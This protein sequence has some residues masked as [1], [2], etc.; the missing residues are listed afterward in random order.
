M[1]DIWEKVKD[2]IKE[3]IPLRSYLL[4]IKPIKFVQKKGRSII[5]GCPNRFSCK[6]IEQNYLHLLKETF[7][8]LLDE[9]IQI[10]LR[11]IPKKEE[12]KE[13]QQLYL[14]DSFRYEK[15]RL[16]KNF[17]FEKFVVG[18]CNEFAY[19][20]SSAFAKNENWNYGILLM[21]AEPGLGKTHLSQAAGNLILSKNPALKVV[22][23]TVEDFL[24]DLIYAV[25]TKQIES[26]KER[27]RKSCDVLLLEGIH[28]LSGKERTQIELAYTLDCL[29]NE[30][31]KV[32][33]T[34]CIPPNKI[35]GLSKELCS[36]LTSG[37]IASIKPP[38]YE[39]RF[40]IILRKSMEQG[41]KLKEE[42]IHFLASKITKDVRQMESVITCLKAKADLMK[43]EIDLELAEETV[44]Q[45][46]P[47]ESFSDVL[48][49]IMEVV[50]RYFKTDP[51]E[52][53][54][55]SRKKIPSM[56]R[57]IFVYLAKKHTD[58]SFEEIAKKIKRSHSTAIYAIESLKKKMDKDLKIKSQVELLDKKVSEIIYSIF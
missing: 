44:S 55:N 26:F 41:I 17:V 4:W 47:P 56:A 39:T 46:I 14:G 37:I 12:K 6:W 34:S 49:K 54:S 20:A 45:I 40:K 21:L 25:R 1:E 42:I 11:V 10:Q 28:F 52:L 31:K 13:M 32:I 51:E 22:Y 58:K 18:P 19:N 43:A 38:D 29:V 15:I 7:S 8:S 30:R 35:P 16:N 48:D 2:R 50:C 5:L 23:I 53:C 36:R 24:N 33:I 3:R 9:K 27:Y 57:S